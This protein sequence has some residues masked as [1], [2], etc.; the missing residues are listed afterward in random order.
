[1]DWGTIRAK[2]LREP[3][4]AAF[5]LYF[6][7]VGAFRRRTPVRVIG[8]H[9]RP[10]LN[11]KLFKLLGFV[12][13]ETGALTFRNLD[14]TF[15]EAP[16]DAINGRCTDISKSK[17]AEVFEKVFGYELTVDPEAHDGPMVEKSEENATHDGRVVQGPMAPRPGLVYQHLVDNEQD[18]VVEDLRPC[19]VGREI[20]FV[21]RKRRPV[22]IRFSNDNT[23]ITVATPDDVFSPVE[24]QGVLD[25]ADA[26]GLDV[27]ELDVLRDRASGRI[28]VVDAAK[29]PHSPGEACVNWAGIRAMRRA[30]AAFRREFVDGGTG[31]RRA[32][33][34]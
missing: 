34:Q 8:T 2:G 30:A 16:A 26:L 21:Y 23:S 5:Y 33:L 18:G 29:T 7:V 17:V 13:A 25:V 9:R 6:Y 19:I 3:R 27:G 20:A 11:W 24:Q 14:A 15:D 10:Y 31:R 4:K 1:M 32:A 28:Y 12:P 22:A